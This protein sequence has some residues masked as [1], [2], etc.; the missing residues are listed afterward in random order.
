M[1]NLLLFVLVEYVLVQLSIIIIIILQ[2]EGKSF[3]LLKNVVKI[4]FIFFSHLFLKLSL[5]GLF[6]CCFAIF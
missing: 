2:S 4:Y 3:F 6:V 5:M 1:I